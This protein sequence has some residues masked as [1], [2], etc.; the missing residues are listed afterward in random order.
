MRIPAFPLRD[1]VFLREFNPFQPFLLVSERCWANFGFN[2]AGNFRV[3]WHWRCLAARKRPSTMIDWLLHRPPHRCHPVEI[4]VEER[5]RRV[6]AA[7]A[8][9]PSI[10]SSSAG[11]TRP[12][13][14]L[15]RP[16]P[17]RPILP[18]QKPARRPPR[19][20]WPQPPR[21]CRTHT[22]VSGFQPYPNC[23]S[24]TPPSTR[25]KATTP[26]PSSSSACRLH[27]LPVDFPKHATFH[28]H[29]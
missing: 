23:Q 17:P 7:P 6:T 15:R 5:R 21:M 14:S 9:T 13:S 8:A 20:R 22:S 16:Y 1:V 4:R 10:S 11:K 3:L 27:S 2:A 29:N 24:A 25:P 26:R 28:F 12:L 19:T 18:R